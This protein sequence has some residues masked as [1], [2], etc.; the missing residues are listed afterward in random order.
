MLF[1]TLSFPVSSPFS[2][3]ELST[4]S[5][6]I[7]PIVLPENFIDSPFSFLTTIPNLSESGS[8]AI[9][10]SAPISLAFFIPSS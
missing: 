9:T 5:V 6:S 4:Y 8:V 2:F 1:I 7:A 10:T 3:N